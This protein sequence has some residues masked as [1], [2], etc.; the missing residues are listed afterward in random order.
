MTLYPLT[1]QSILEIS[2][3]DAVS[4]LQGYCTNDLSILNEG[5]ASYGA[6]TN[7]QGRIETTFVA[8]LD[9]QHAIGEGPGPHLMLRMPRSAIPHIHQF[10]S[11]YVIFSKAKIVDRSHDLHCYGSLTP[12]DQAE[13]MVI[14]IPQRPQGFELWTRQSLTCHSDPS[15]WLL[16]ELKAKLIWLE[17][18]QAGAFQPFELD[19]TTNGGVNF[20]KGCYLGQEIIARV[21]YRGKPKTELILATTDRPVQAGATVTDS[22][23]KA[24]GTVV[25]AVDSRGGAHLAAVVNVARG[26][27]ALMI[28]EHPLTTL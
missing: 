14:D 6:I 20:D 5:K 13:G 26:S 23:G 21:H 28:G 7:L 3:R 10:L 19:L 16:A 4:F 12:T 2:G 22:S 17:V 8:A 27:S 24:C 11:Q 25:N 1:H 9:E 18:A 15:P